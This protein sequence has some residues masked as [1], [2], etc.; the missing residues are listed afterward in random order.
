M[1]ELTKN[2]LKELKQFARG[3]AAR[4]WCDKE[5]ESIEM[6][7]RLAEA[8]AKRLFKLMQVVKMSYIAHWTNSPYLEMEKLMKDWEE[9]KL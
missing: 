4:C 6:D 5:T 1:S 3:V 9:G 2:E 8:F 7:V